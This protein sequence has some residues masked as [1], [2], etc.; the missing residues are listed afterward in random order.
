MLM[1]WPRPP[2]QLKS[3]PCTLKPM[4]F[5]VRGFFCLILPTPGFSLKIKR[6][7]L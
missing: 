1:V 7:I 4:C 2:A 5:Y 6:M 3:R